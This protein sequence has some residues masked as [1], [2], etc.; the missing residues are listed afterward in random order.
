MTEPVELRA[1]L[2]KLNARVAVGCSAW[3]GVDRF[4]RI[5]SERKALIE[6]RGRCASPKERAV[7]EASDF[8]T[9]DN[10]PPCREAKAWLT[11]F[12]S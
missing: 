7:S 12:R 4:I 5:G 8:Q 3:L 11:A 6:S 9:F 1:A 10:S 2:R